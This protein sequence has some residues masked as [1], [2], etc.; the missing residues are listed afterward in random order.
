MTNETI[1]LLIRH[2]L[3]ALW[4]ILAASGIGSSEQLGELTEPLVNG[5]GAASLLTGLI[6]SYLRKKRTKTV[7]V[8]PTT[9][10]TETK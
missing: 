7:I 1:K 3:T 9:T 4:P 2:G 8:T 6:W 5:I 10:K